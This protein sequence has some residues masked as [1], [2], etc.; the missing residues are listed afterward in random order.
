[1][2]DTHTI[3]VRFP[4]GIVPQYSAATEFQGGQV[5][6]VNFGGDQLA[7]AQE[8][9]EALE[10]IMRWWDGDDGIDEQ[11]I[12]ARHALAKARGEQS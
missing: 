7:V 5:T 6:A 3:V 9:E 4:A 10:E 1:M 2:S 12:A 11:F 8:L